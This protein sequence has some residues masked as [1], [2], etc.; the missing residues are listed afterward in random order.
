MAYM[1]C[2][3]YGSGAWASGHGTSEGAGGPDSSLKWGDVFLRVLL[4]EATLIPQLSTRV[5]SC[6]FSTHHRP[7]PKTR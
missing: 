5:N 6:F 2:L 4:G 3:G 7:P 1:E